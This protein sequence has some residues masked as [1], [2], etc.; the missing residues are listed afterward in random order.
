MDYFIKKCRESSLK[1]TPQRIAIY[2]VI[3][4]DKSHPSADDVYKKIVKK[5]PTISFDT[6]N[7]TL[8]SFLKIGLLGNVE[9]S[10]NSK[11]Y[12]SFTHNHHHIHCIK[13]GNIVDFESREFDKIKIPSSFL[14]K[15]KILNKKVVFE[16]IC[17]KCS[18][19][20]NK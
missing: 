3:L 20:K 5:Y 15:N 2:K 19:L 11:R 17:E 16:V 14:K 10:G 8:I 1:V 4:G 7:R 12:D 13:C 18:K 6:V 9:G